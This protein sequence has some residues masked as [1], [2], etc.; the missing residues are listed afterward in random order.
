VIPE[1]R[2]AFNAGFTEAKYARFLRLLDDGSGTHV[3]FRN[4]ETPC[5]FPRLLMDKLAQY[6]REMILQLVGNPD[7]LAAADATIPAEFRVAGDEGKPLFV[8]V[9]FGLDL[10]GEPKLVEIQGFPSLYAYQ[11]F[12]TE[13]Y[14]SAYGI[15]LSLGSMLGGFDMESYADRVRRAIVGEHDPANVALLEIDPH[16]QK[17]LCDFLLTERMC[18]IPIVN[19]RDVMQEGRRLFYEKDGKRIAIERIY[20]RVIVDELQRKSVTPPFD[21]RDDLDVEWAGHPNWYYKISKFS[22]PYLNHV[23][24]P[25]CK[26][27]TEIETLPDNLED[28]VLKPLFSFAGLGVRVSP[29]LDEVMQVRERSDYILQERIDFASPIETPYGPTKC[30]IRIMYIWLDELTPCTALVRM[31]RGKMMGVDHNRDLRWVGA[32]AAFIA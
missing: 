10:N 1:L 19:L 15:D 18:G 30:E 28:Y 29:T 27:L 20:N 32:S 8:Q 16:E 7:Y 4:C 12:L 26:F 24:A 5:F 21:F 31:G 9:D 23:A 14:R 11:P 17:T 3:L 2:R 13:T 25:P 6:G 22:L